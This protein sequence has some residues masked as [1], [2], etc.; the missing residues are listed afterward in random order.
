[1]LFCCYHFVFTQV[2][3]LIINRPGSTV[4]VNFWVPQLFFKKNSIGCPQQPPTE[5]VSNISGKLDFWWSIPQ[6]G[7]IIGHFGARD[8]PNIWIRK[9][10]WWNRVFE[11]VE[12][13]EAAEAAE[14]NE[15][16]EVL[17]PGKSLLRTVESSRFL[18]LTLFW[19]FEK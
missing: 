2:F 8:D 9:F 4:I 7:T 1:M 18:N 6:K 11:A 15:A 12:A 5:K 14:V 13:S 10:F 3:F 17:R 16:A 19:C